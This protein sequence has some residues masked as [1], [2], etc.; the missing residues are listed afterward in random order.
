[1]ATATLTLRSDINATLARLRIARVVDD[2]DEI[3]TC[4]R[5]LDWLLN[6][7]PRDTKLEEP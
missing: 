5:R 4:E 6:Q 3:R 2:R 7:I 1:M